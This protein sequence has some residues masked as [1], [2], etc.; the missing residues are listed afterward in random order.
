[1]RGFVLNNGQE[2][3]DDVQTDSCG[4]SGVSSASGGCSGHNLNSGN[5][6]SRFIN[7]FS[8]RSFRGGLKRTKSVTKLD[9][10][11][12]SKPEPP[13]TPTFHRSHHNLALPTQ[14][15]ST[16][17]FLTPFST[18]RLSRS[19]ESLATEDIDPPPMPLA[20]PPACTCCRNEQ[21]GGSYNTKQAIRKG[22]QGDEEDEWKYYDFV[23]EPAGGK[24]LQFGAMKPIVVDKANESATKEIKGK[25]TLYT[26]KMSIL[27]A[28]GLASKKRFYCE[29]YL[30]QTQYGKTSSKTKSQEMGLFWG[31]QFDFA[32]LPNVQTLEVHLYRESE[33]KKA[34]KN[35]DRHALI[36]KVVLP[37]MALSAAQ[38]TEK[39]YPVILE[40]KLRHKIRRRSNTN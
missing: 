21:I 28:K 7:F 3:F 2:Q 40:K 4:S 25:R 16:N 35:K 33:H 39:W 8:K 11:Q 27:E 38:L 22:I 15:P 10:R 6:Q 34:K 37:I 18:S 14:L 30:D 23:R 12:M 31:E 24:Q 20:P 5:L 13:I 36:G 19:H 17:S 32:R 29:I 26:M 9:R 1:M